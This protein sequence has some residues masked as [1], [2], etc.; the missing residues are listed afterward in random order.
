MLN[1][2]SLFS[3]CLIPITYWKIALIAI[4]NIP[5]GTAIYNGEKA[6]G[7]YFKG[8]TLTAVNK[9]YATDTNWSKGVYKWMMYLY[10]KL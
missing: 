9:S 6:V 3:R 10:N 2:L 5:K 7:T 1:P 4:P 8:A